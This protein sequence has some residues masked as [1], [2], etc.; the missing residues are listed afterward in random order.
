MEPRRQEE[1]GS[2][3]PPSPTWSSWPGQAEWTEGLNST[4]LRNLIIMLG[5]MFECLKGDSGRHKNWP[6]HFWFSGSDGEH[7][8]TLLMGSGGAAE[9]QTHLSS[10]YR[11]SSPICPNKGATSSYKGRSTSRNLLQTSLLK[12]HTIGTITIPLLK[13]RNSGW[14]S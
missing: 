11:L 13:R 10:A 3:I 5:L 14:K 6:E 1:G 9:E 12:S 8:R 4:E 7:Y 2:L